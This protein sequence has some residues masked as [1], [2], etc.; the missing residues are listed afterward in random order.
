M[1]GRLPSDLLNRTDRGSQAA[2]WP[3][4]LQAARA[5]IYQELQQLESVDLARRALDL[6][7]MRAV[8]E[9]FS[10]GT[11]PYLELTQYQWLLSALFTG[12]F[13]RLFEQTEASADQ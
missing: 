3:A 7:G 12:R 4:R 6:P 9:R 13:I 5:D 11:T 2:D 1:E 10:P 8:M